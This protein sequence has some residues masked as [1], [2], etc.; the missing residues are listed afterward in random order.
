LD[1]NER[2]KYAEQWKMSANHFLNNLDYDWMADCISGYN[3]V[4]EIGAGT[5]HSTL[6]LA[7]K[8]HKIIAIEKNEYCIEKAK[9]L[10]R[11]NGV[12]YCDLN[13][14]EADATVVFINSDICDIYIDQLSNYN[15]DV[16]VCWNIGTHWSKDMMKYY[17]GKMLNY[18]LTVDQIREN[19]E[20]SY[21]EFIQWS[22]VESARNLGVPVHIV[23]RNLYSIN[24]END[25]YYSTLRDEFNYESILYLSRESSSISI[26]GRPLTS[27]DGVL[28]DDIVQVVLVS[29]LMF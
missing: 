28:E 2:I 25:Q 14:I 16:V 3:C 23:D 6:K 1:N 9:E 13:S 5:G 15:I 22:A 21:G 10:L 18:G 12:S 24:E 20:S 29:I 8:G 26:G 17:L 4:L 7:Q 19:M 27:E 11:C